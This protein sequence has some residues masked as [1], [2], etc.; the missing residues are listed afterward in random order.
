M[1]GH[2]ATDA[3]HTS[4]AAHSRPAHALLLLLCPVTP[5]PQV[6][7][8]WKAV[9]YPSL[10]PLGSYLEGL[11]ARLDMLA[12]WAAAGSPPPAFWLPGFF[13]VQSFL[14]AGLQNYARKH[15]IPID[16]VGY[17]FEMLGMDHKRYPA[18]PEEV[19]VRTCSRG[20]PRR[21]YDDEC[22]ICWGVLGCRCDVCPAL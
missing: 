18:A 8:L 17:D 14:T 7:D 6:P 1:V 10:K 12:S 5:R 21:G 16:M 4:P 19:G 13:F 2:I 20:L 9:S 15:T 22:V 11:Y 3:Q